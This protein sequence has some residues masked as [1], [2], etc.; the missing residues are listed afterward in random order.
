LGLKKSD[1]SAKS[2]FHQVIE[3]RQE[4]I[5][6]LIDVHIMIPRVEWSVTVERSP[7]LVTFRVDCKDNYASDDLQCSL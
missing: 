6:N 5:S 4:I 7:V 2:F 1:I 3:V